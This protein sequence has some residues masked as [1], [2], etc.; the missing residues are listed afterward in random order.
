MS[1]I[2]IVDSHCDTLLKINSGEI[3][4][5]KNAAAH[6]DLPKL[7][8]S[9]VVIQF[10]AVYIHSVYKPGL[11]LRR[12]LELINN[13]L[14]I[15]KDPKLIH[16]KNKEDLEIVISKYPEKTGILLSLEGAEPIE[17]I[18]MLDIFAHLGVRSIG[19]TWNH[20]NMIADGCNETGGLTSFGK[21]IVNRM[22][23]LGILCDIS[24]LSPA[25]FWDVISITQNPLIASHS[26]CHALCP[27]L[28][29]LTDNQIKEIAKTGGI[30]SITF[31]P[32]FIGLK[33][34]VNSIVAH[35]RH[36]TD[37]VGVDH[38]GIGSDF[39]G[40]D[41]SINNLEDSSRLPNLIKVLK[42]NGFNDQEIA[43]VMGNNI[44]GLLKK[45]LPRR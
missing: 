33:Q 43:K 13:F 7:S 14:D 5:F 31:Y 11:S 21:Q 39:D 15:A 9:G 37:L 42:Q 3:D 12:S 8:Q 18:P 17:S 44:I 16:I 4:F 25:S 29:N 45:T 20:R 30:I 23:E 36:V 22:T 1:N 19:L 26:N 24:H 38:V 35:I 41:F 2:K 27:H 34:D 40:A 6:V 32:D 10:M 28:R